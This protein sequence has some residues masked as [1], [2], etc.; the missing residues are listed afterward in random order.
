MGEA[1]LSGKVPKLPDF[2]TQEKV[3]VVVD[4]EVKN[5]VIHEVENDKEHE[6]LIAIAN[7]FTGYF[8]IVGTRYKIEHLLITREALPLIGLG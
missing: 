8:D 7:R 5:Y 6:G 2:V 1:F 4:S 3:F